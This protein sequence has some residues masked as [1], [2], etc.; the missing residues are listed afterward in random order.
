[1]TEGRAVHDSAET[2]DECGTAIPTT[3]WALINTHL[4]PPR[5]TKSSDR[6]VVAPAA[7]DHGSYAIY[8]EVTA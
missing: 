8:R 4:T 6:E 7:W 5:V 1:M 3:A 2:C